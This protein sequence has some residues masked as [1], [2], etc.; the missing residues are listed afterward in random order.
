MEKKRR[1]RE[2]QIAKAERALP[3]ARRYHEAKL[4]KIEDDRVALDRLA[5]GRRLEGYATLFGT[6]E[7][8]PSVSHAG[9]MS[10]SQCCPV[11]FI[12]LWQKTRLRA[13]VGARIKLRRQ[14]PSSSGVDSQ[15]EVGS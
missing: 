3:Q 1:R 8:G 14:L 6:E 9:R 15:Q 7:P 10:S 5:K 13:G 4:K 2:Q 11:R 12:T